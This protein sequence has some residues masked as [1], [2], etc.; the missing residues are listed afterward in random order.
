M[1]FNK[2]ERP[3]QR[4]KVDP[5]LKTDATFHNS[6][7][8]CVIK[9]FQDIKQKLDEYFYFVKTK[10]QGFL[11]PYFQRKSEGKFNGQEVAT[12]K[13]DPVVKIV[14]FVSV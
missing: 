14:I 3:L 6:L 9:V 2:R 12:L 13:V 8:L 10:D 11:V 1:S 4:F 7:D 5:V